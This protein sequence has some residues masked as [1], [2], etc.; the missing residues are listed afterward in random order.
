MPQ[1]HT[2]GELLKGFRKREGW[3]QQ[4]LANELGVDRNTIGNWE[5]SQYL[6]DT[7]EIVLTLASVLQLSHAVKYPKN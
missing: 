6:P 5:R 2:F 4:E 7:R 3:T 1:S